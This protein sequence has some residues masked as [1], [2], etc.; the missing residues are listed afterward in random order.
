MLTVFP[1]LNSTETK[2]AKLE[3]EEENIVTLQ[4]DYLEDVKVGRV[5][6]TFGV[7]YFFDRFCVGAQGKLPVMIKFMSNEFIQKHFHEGI[8]E[9]LSELIAKLKTVQHSNILSFHGLIQHENQIGLVIAFP[10]LNLCDW[11][12]NEADEYHHASLPDPEKIFLANISVDV[13]DAIIHAHE[14]NWV[15]GRLSAQHV[16]LSYNFQNEKLEG[17]VDVY[18]AISICQVLSQLCKCKIAKSVKISPLNYSYCSPE[19]LLRRKFT[20]RSDVWC[21]GIFLW[22]V[23]NLGATPYLSI[24]DERSPESIQAFVDF[25]CQPNSKKLSLSHD[26]DI[27][28]VIAQCQLITPKSRITPHQVQQ[29]LQQK[30]KTLE[31]Q[32]NTEEETDP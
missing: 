12:E 9:Q 5:W 29:I 2:D 31:Q 21:F 11:L 17:I 19:V 23:W 24:L 25:I 10:K 14:N 28:K 16:F 4:I 30:L 32:T 20:A 15:I 27:N 8:E 13:N 1:E 6:K 7:R 22:E 26:E 18:S 3:G